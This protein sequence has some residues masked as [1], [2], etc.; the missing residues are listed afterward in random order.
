MSCCLCVSFVT[1]CPTD[2][3]CLP[4]HPQPCHDRWRT[5]P[6]KSLSVF[7]ETSLSERSPN[8][9]K[10]STRIKH[11]EKDFACRINLVFQNTL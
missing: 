10:I 1:Q 9:K 8:T 7:L 3:M 6:Y 11:S 4:S 2:K 5:R